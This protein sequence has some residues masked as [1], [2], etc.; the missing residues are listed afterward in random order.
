VTAAYAPSVTPAAAV[1]KE[2]EANEL[3]GL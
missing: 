2:S 1:R 3:V